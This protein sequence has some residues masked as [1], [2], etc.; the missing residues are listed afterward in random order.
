MLICQNGGSCKQKKDESGVEC[1]CS[2]GFTG[3]LCDVALLPEV[4]T[5]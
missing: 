5:L 1:I 2:S 3:A 4:A